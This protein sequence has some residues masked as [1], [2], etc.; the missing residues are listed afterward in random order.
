M[1]KLDR[2][3]PR[4][5]S[6]TCQGTGLGGRTFKQARMHSATPLVSSCL[7][8]SN[9][10]HAPCDVKLE[11]WVRVGKFMIAAVGCPD[12]LIKSSPLLPAPSHSPFDCPKQPLTAYAAPLLA[13]EVFTVQEHY[14]TQRAMS[15]CVNA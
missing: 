10:V 8:N 11:L 13:N 7:M 14:C 12:Q 9:R 5:R 1:N 15:A 2:K 6:R 3:A 4:K